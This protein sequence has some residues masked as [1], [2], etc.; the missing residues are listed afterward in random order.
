V[1]LSGLL[2]EWIAVCAERLGLYVE[3][4]GDGTNCVLTLNQKWIGL[5]FGLFFTNSFDQPDGTPQSLD[6]A[7]Q[8]QPI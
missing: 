6:L 8:F 3:F 5:F 1:L 2:L 4:W 7:L